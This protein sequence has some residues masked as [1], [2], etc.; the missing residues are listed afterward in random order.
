MINLSSLFE[1]EGLSS[2]NDYRSLSSHF[3]R[4]YHGVDHLPLG[5]GHHFRLDHVRVFMPSMR[6]CVNGGHPIE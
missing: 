1:V 5:V 2:F 6:F 4:V 3:E